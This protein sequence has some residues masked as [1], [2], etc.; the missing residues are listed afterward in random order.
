MA[1]SRRSLLRGAGLGAL[2]GGLTL[3]ARG[4]AAK[5]KL[6]QKAAHYQT[7]PKDGHSCAGCRHFQPKTRSCEIV[8]GTIVP[9]GW[10]MMWAPKG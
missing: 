5:H 8:A 1:L 4:A 2:A 10:C 3:V 9:N 6:A 7:K